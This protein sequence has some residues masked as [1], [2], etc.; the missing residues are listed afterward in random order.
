MQDSIL[1]VHLLQFT[2]EAILDLE[3]IHGTSCYGDSAGLGWLREMLHA[4]HA[5]DRKTTTLQNKIK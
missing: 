5:H 4:E 1:L 2:F 3:W